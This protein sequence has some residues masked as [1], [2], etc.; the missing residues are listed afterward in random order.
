[1]ASVHLIVNKVHAIRI[2]HNVAIRTEIRDLSMVKSDF[3]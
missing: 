2:R 3:L 1:M